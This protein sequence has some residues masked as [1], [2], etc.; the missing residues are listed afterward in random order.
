MA[1]EARQILA[2][3]LDD[4]SARNK[5]LQDELEATYQEVARLRRSDPQ[6]SRAPLGVVIS[7]DI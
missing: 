5:K 3:E 4:L 1:E 2:W 7:L 6:A